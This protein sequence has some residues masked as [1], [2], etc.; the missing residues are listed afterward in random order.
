MQTRFQNMRSAAV[1]IP[2]MAVL[3]GAF[4][5]SVLLPVPADAQG[6]GLRGGAVSGPNGGAAGSRGLMSNGQG[7]VAAGRNFIVG[8]GQGNGVARSG[9]CASN[10]N[11]AGCSGRAAAWGSDG[12]FRGGAGTEITGEDRFFSGNRSLERDADGNWSGTRGVDAAGLNGSYSGDSNFADGAYSRGATYSGTEG[13]SATVEG[14]YELG[15]G[16]S[17]SVTCIDASGTVVTCP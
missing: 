7:G 16:G 13:Q 10:V 12:T 6:F 2:A 4:A 8:D 1:A 5:L 3:V 14:A 15:S 17:R 11:A 9:G